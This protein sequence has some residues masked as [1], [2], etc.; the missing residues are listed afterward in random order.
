[1]AA[2]VADAAGADRRARAP[3][4]ALAAVFLARLEEGRVA[5]E[6]GALDEAAAASAR[7]LDAARPGAADLAEGAAGLAGGGAAGGRSGRRLADQTG[8]AAPDKA[9]EQSPP[10]Q[11]ACPFPRQAIEPPRVHYVH[12]HPSPCRQCAIAIRDPGRVVRG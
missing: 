4:A 7:L 9:A 5:A 8:Q 12:P 11:S 3:Q 1:V 6:A 2:A 10:R